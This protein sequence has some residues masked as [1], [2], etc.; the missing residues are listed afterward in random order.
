MRFRVLTRDI[1]NSDWIN[2]TIKSKQQPDLIRTLSLESEIRFELG[3][4]DGTI[5]VDITEDK[6]S[7]V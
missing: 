5:H 2:F 3:T 6:R 7:N 4:T 1:P